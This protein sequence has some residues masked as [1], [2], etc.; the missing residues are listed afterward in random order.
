MATYDLDRVEINHLL[1][2]NIDPAARAAAV[3]YLLNSGAFDDDDD[4]DNKFDDDHEHYSHHHGDPTFK[5]EVSD[6]TIPLDPQAQLVDLTTANNV[7]DTTDPALKVIVE[8]VSGDSQLS[9]LHG[10]TDVMIV[11][12][13]G[14]DQVDLHDVGNDIVLTGS[15]N[16]T[17]HAGDGAD[18]VYGGAG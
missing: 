4:D 13:N 18:S 14:N 5:V 8:N 6:G 2:P 16:D 1:T 7:V 15:G 11:T 12:G 10:D 3:D 17:V 9:V